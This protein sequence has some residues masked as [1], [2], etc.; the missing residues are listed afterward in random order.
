MNATWSPGDTLPDR[1]DHRAWQAPFF[2]ALRPALEP[3]ATILDIGSGRR[4]TLAQEERPPGCTYVGFDRSQAEL[5]LAPAGSYDRTVVGDVQ[6]GMA[7]LESSFDL[8]ISWQVLEHVRS[9][10]AAV[11][12]IRSYLRPG[13]LFVGLLSGKFALFGLANHLVPHRAAAWAMHRMLGRDPSSVFPAYYDRCWYSALTELG[14]SWS[15][16]SVEP[17]HAGAAY[18]AFSP[19]LQRLYLSYEE[20][21]IRT[22]RRNL[23]THYLLVGER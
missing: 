13:G 15:A 5:D 3:G 22:R 9:L 23:A 14:G 11:G 6:H 19:R 1:Y 4:P 8:V 21:V 10:G 12:T 20:W 17:R 18:L 7:E 16:F 2:E